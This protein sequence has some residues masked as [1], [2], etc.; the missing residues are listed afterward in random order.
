MANVHHIA[1]G[2]WS[3]SP[4]PE[5]PTSTNTMLRTQKIPL[6][7]VLLTIVFPV[8][9]IQSDSVMGHLTLDSVGSPFTCK[10]E[11]VIHGFMNVC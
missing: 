4:I 11:T 10:D 6:V 7:L 3:I 2:L 9:K 8:A 5:T 1:F